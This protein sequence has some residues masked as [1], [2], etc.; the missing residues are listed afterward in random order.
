MIITLALPLIEKIANAALKHDPNALTKLATIENQVIQVQ[1]TDWRIIFHIIPTKSGLLFEKKPPTE[2]NTVIKSTLP[3][4]LKLLS[5][6]AETSSLFHYPVD[7]S[8]STRDL[9]V[10]RDVFANL[11]IDWEEALSQHVGDVIAHK[12]CFHANKAIDVKNKTKQKLGENITEYLH[13]E[14]RALPTGDELE[15]FYQDIATLKNDIDR[16][17]AKINDHNA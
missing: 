8:G 4:F 10:L 15:K 11:D 16:L 7:I 9:E 1:C 13:Y 5:K 12:L 17:E 2:P 6:G 14:A 3:N